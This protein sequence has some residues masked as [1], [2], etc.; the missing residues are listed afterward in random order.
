MSPRSLAW[1]LCAA[2]V[3]L[4]PAPRAA[5]AP[6]EPVDPALAAR[7]DAAFIYAF[8]LYE[9]ARARWNAMVN[10]LNPNPS[11]V[12]GTPFHK[13]KL[14]DHRD[15]DVTTPNN[16]TLY[17]ATWLDLSHTPVRIELPRITGGRYWSVAMLDIFSNN[18]AILGRMRD[19]EG[20]LQA[21]VVGPGWDGP[22]P[23]GS[24]V[25]SPTNDVQLIGRFLVDGPADAPMVHAIQDAL[26]IA[27]LDPAVPLNHQW[28]AASTSREP[29]NFLAVVNEMLARNPVPPDERDM[30][31]G[32]R[33]LGIGG[34][35]DAFV[36]TSPA[37]QAAWKARLPAL[38]ERVGVGL[39][40][41]GRMV[42]GWSVPSAAV[43]DFGTDYLLR[44]AVAFGG[45]SALAANEAIYL[46]L[47]SDPSTGEPLDGARR[48]RLVVPPIDTT[49][50]WSISMYE[51]DADGRLFFS[52]NPIGRY[53]I[54]DRTKGVHRQRD[55]SVVVLLQH[56]RP[57]DA[58]NWL[59]APRGAFALTLRVYGPSE[60]MRRGEAAL[61]RLERN[62]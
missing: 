34:G 15:R 56:E 38:H 61:P 55:G 27:Q 10:P 26:R 14:I 31:A 53:S 7:V 59:P 4:P 36:R 48:Y 12:N 23:T 5:D 29:A 46:N 49:A 51:K 32:W 54:G 39:L 19:G 20:P 16:D 3:A 2:L 44:A 1:M 18:F 9:M 6:P 13:R 62:D 11:P 45:L 37:V 35:Y 60:S 25:R 8:P 57:R 22:L 40:H 30:V 43:G 21:T 47:E 33:D 50:F 58:S 24:I 41:G 28:V 17:S 52:E 42:Q